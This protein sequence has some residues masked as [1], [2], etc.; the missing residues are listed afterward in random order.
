MSRPPSGQGLG[1]TARPGMD[2][3]RGVV[4]ALGYG[5]LAPIFLLTGGRC[6]K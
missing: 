1:R 2:V 6:F 4:F 5:H 3:Q